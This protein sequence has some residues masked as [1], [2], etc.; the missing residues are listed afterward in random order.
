MQNLFRHISQEEVCQDLD[1]LFGHPG[2]VLFRARELSEVLRY[3]DQYPLPI[4]KR[5]L[6]LG[7]AEGRI[8]KML[9]NKI[10]VGLDLDLS[11][12]KQARGASI[13]KNLVFASATQMPFK[14]GA[15]DVVFSNS[16]IEHIKGIEQ[17]LSEA[18]RVLCKQGLFVFTV[19]SHKFSDY[20][21][22][23]TIFKKSGLGLIKL[24][25]SY[26][27]L[28]NKQL[29]HFNLFSESAWENKLNN[30]SFEV[31][32]KKY[33]LSQEDIYFWDK[34]CILL[35]ISRPLGLRKKLLEKFSQRVK[36]RTRKNN[37]VALGAGLLLVARKK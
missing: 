17:V 27:Y 16:V 18:S 33:Y 21:Y 3:F 6:D 19:P 22:L 20:L 29:N 34:I 10:D 14:A 13:Y 15:F 26:A 11:E 1:R 36:E 30:F 32:Y 37:E 4:E 8:G 24:D 7:C 5:V 9:F 28:R 23:S 35:R 12:L 31:I 2:T 25:N